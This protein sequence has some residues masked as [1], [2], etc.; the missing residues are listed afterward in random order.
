MSGP[1]HSATNGA[2]RRGRSRLLRGLAL[3][4]AALLI[5]V[6]AA[7][8]YLLG[9]PSGLR[10]ALTQAERLSGG[11]VR[12][13]TASGTLLGKLELRDLRY[14]GADGT[15]I[16][17]GRIQLRYRPDEL[18]AGRF[19]V[20][21]L[22]IDTVDITPGKGAQP[23]PAANASIRLPATLPL[24]VVIDALSLDGLSLHT[25][26]A[27]DG[28][29]LRIEHAAFAG[30]WLGTQVEVRELSTALPQTGPLQ[31]QAKL[32]MAGDR[33]EI[34]QLQL[35]GPGE[36]NASGTL[37]LGAAQSAL[38]LDFAGLHYPL[39]PAE[40]VPA[41]VDA[42]RGELQLDGTAEQFHYALH[43]EATVRGQV[44]RLSAN[45]SGSSAG[46]QID[47]LQ[48]EVLA[49]AAK[50]SRGKTAETTAAVRSS[51]QASGHV[52]WAPQFAAELQVVLS[53]VDPAL[54]V[55]GLPGDINGRIDSRS[56]LDGERPDIVFKADIT[57]STLR[58]QPFSLQADGDTD[59]QRAHL[60]SLTLVAGK[61]R[62][63]AQGDI[64]WQPRLS[65]NLEARISRLD[66]G[67]FVDGWPGRLNGRA[68]LQTATGPRAPIGFS[69]Q[70]ADSSLRGYPLQLDARGAIANQ[71]TVTLE[72]F[73]L[74]SGTTQIA[75]SGQVTPPFA[76]QGR[77]DSPD[78]GALYPKLSGRAAFDFQ[79]AGSLKQPH[80][81]T[82]G[83]ASA[84][85]YGEQAVQQLRWNADVDPKADSKITVTLSDADAGL[86]IANARLQVTGVEVYHRLE[87]SAD[88]ERGSAS[89]AVQ[90]GFD[91]KRFEWG[92]EL[93]ALRFTAKGLS[94]WSLDK[95]A[96]LL[97]GRKRR[98]LEPAC[99]QGEEGRACFNLEQ[100]V[101]GNGIRLGWNIEHLLLAT[102]Q[103]F[104]P[105]GFGVS[106]SVEG[107]GHL[108][109]TGSDIAE[110]MATLNL[111]QA[112]LQVPDGPPLVLDSGEL[113]AMQGQDGRLHMRAALSTAQGRLSADAS[114]APGARIG[115]RPLSG[116]LKIDLPSLAFIDPLLPQLRALDGRMSGDVAIA[117]TLREPRF[118]GAL[119]L[120]Q[121]QARLVAAGIDLKDVTLRLRADGSSTIAVDGQ[122]HSGGGALKL[123]GTV[124]PFATPLNLQLKLDGEA[125]QVLNTAQARA[126]VSPQLSL[127]RDA[128]GATLTGE[129]V[130][131]R[132][133]I[134]PKGFGGGGVEVSQD[135]VLVGVEAPPP[136]TPLPVYAKLHLVLGNKVR[137]EGFGLKTRIEGAVDVTQE[138]QH[139][140]LGRGRLTLVDGEY[141]AYGQDLKIETGRLI[142]TGG[143]VVAPAVDIYATRRPREDITVGVRVR[144]TLKKPEL[145]LESSPPLPRE[146]QLSWLVLGRS[147][148]TT[149][150]QDR[151]LV[152]SAALSLGLGGGDI[153]AGML[154]KK[155]GLDELSVGG[156]PVGGSEVAASS[157]NISGAQSTAGSTDAGAQAAQLTLGKYL[158]PRLFISYGVSLFQQ[159]YTFRL[160]Y[161]LGH[162]FKL[163]TESGTASG[164]DLIYQ[165]ERGLR[166][167]PAPKPAEDT[168]SAGQTPP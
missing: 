49:A 37:G 81:I 141:K 167:K 63:Q 93:A 110:A 95:P 19:H 53:H 139:E 7:G 55:A 73:R 75:A 91:R 61:G 94:P 10:F 24:D 118:T 157:Q 43:S 46:T 79:L 160:L 32:R 27:A 35:R 58:G 131:P 130:V 31:L 144:G 26:A 98:A 5:A 103:P 18:L 51:I 156:A 60:A 59:T 145:T 86:H 69:I 45:G 80:L 138:P 8:G 62:V 39:L 149:S 120:D 102:F 29:P 153:L 77:F 28:A 104:L 151:S 72:H 123:T 90:G 17:V 150:A 115:D 111:R 154:G 142:F 159:G 20:L 140:A 82:Q 165:T 44:A 162:G 12:V 3:L 85:K 87:L 148:E 114:A 22:A 56:T 11:A 143:P 67:L 57:R 13:G 122:L 30:Q 116:T 70:F 125:F 97:L 78:L 6:L 134:T 137:I 113:S 71:K 135:Q 146:Q 101:L 34:E 128:R 50:S 48:L 1:E 100:N 96:G 127:Q 89:L 38:K 132:A 164:G 108:N 54:V 41:R 163:S 33:L 112:R 106:G 84:L 16:S 105:T 23:A 66:P 40:G 65:A 42:L 161:T 14:S 126:W 52:A 117:G 99:V 119:Q 88:T 25:A 83:Q 158:T 76:A 74:H 4:A 136:E 133:E 64:A 168:P 68:Q 9:T 124:D 2:R 15:V 147:L 107:E 152:S 155:I 36:I 121:G 166:K 109:F 21:R 47:A 129:L 92:G